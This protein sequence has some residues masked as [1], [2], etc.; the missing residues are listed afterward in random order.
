MMVKK[1]GIRMEEKIKC[2]EE[3]EDALDDVLHKHGYTT[4]HTLIRNKIREIMDSEDTFKNK[5]PSKPP[6]NLVIPIV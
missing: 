3:G 6:L 1:I 5:K 2:I 4:D